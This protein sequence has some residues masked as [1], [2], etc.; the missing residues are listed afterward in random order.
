LGEYR[1]LLNYENAVLDR[2]Y[3]LFTSRAY[4]PKVIV[5]YWRSAFVFPA[6]NIRITLDRN[7]R[8]NINHLDLF[9]N[10]RDSMPII[11]EGNQIL[12]VKYDLHFPGFLRGLLANTGSERMAISKYTLARRFHKQPKWEDN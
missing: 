2:I 12:E 6:F 11:L 5:E 4:T 10:V 1:L 7:L 3:A 9:S 8:S